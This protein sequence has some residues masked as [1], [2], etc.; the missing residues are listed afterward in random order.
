MTT[1]LVHCAGCAR[2]W[3]SPTMADGLRLVGSCPRCGGVLVYADDAP[4]PLAAER[5]QASATERVPPPEA[6]L[7]PH[8]VLGLPR[9]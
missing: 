5:V 1:P 3:H 9:R 6:E 4:A 8:L 7:A 2:A